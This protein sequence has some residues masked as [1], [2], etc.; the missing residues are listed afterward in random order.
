LG[1]SPSSFVLSQAERP[2]TNESDK[3]GCKAQRR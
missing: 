3:T 1:A 2:Q